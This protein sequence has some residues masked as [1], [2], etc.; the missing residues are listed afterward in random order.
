VVT[1]AVP[2]HGTL[3]AY[4]DGLYERRGESPDV[5][6]ARLRGAAVGNGSLDELLDG[7]LGVLTP[8][9]CDDDTAIL[10]VRWLT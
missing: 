9:G 6:L 3:L 10:A 5:G 4:T 1:V 7:M 8:A 2:P